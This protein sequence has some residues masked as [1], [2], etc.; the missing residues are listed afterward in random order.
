MDDRELI[1]ALRYLV[2]SKSYIAFHSIEDMKSVCEGCKADFCYHEEDDAH[3]CIY[4]ALNRAADKIAELLAKVEKAERE[5]DVI[6]H[7]ISGICYL[8]KNGK[9]FKSS[10]ALCTCEYFKRRATNREQ[11]CPHFVYRG[12][13]GTSNG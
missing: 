12:L 11:N 6:L 7:D 13:E 8:C 3:W 10:R 2:D 1:E 9:P 5:R 4:E